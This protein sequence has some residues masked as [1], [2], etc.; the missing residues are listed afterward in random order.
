MGMFRD[1]DARRLPL[2]KEIR[3]FFRPL[4]RATQG[5]GLVDMN[6]AAVSVNN[7]TNVGNAEAA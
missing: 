5:A 2:A 1:F 4:R 7:E 6:A 3:A